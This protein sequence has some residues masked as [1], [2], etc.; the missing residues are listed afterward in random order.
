MIVCGLPSVV[1]AFVMLFY[2]PESP[3]F[4]CS[5]GDEQETLEVLKTIYSCN[6]G[7]HRDTF[8]AKTLVKDEDFND[9]T[10]EKSTNLLK[11]MWNQSVPLFKHPHLKNFL[12]ACYI[13]FSIFNSS[14]GF[15]TF[16]PEITNRITLW[17]EKDPT[18][19][20][21]TVCEILVDT[22]IVPS[23][24]ETFID[25]AVCITKLQPS[26]YLNA[27]YLGALYFF[28]WLF[29]VFIIK[30]VGKLII[31]ATV[32][33]TCGLC[34]FALIFVSQPTVSSYL[35]ITLMGDALALSVLNASTVEL[36]PT[37]HR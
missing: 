2:M 4:L 13:Q 3:K 24:N 12:T 37:R 25:S 22:K 31:I 1:C 27:F 8:K 10:E 33:F 21:A 14:N 32:L 28:G 34:G 18:H 11:F 23:F 17:Q 7:K 15:W 16:F 26:A 19:V 29:L 36:F 6:S 20:T 35:Y 30:P 9:S 5:I